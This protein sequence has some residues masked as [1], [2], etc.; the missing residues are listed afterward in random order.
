MTGKE[1]KRLLEEQKTAIAEETERMAE[2]IEREHMTISLCRD[3]SE[4]TDK[5]LKILSSGKTILHRFYIE[6]SQL[7]G[8]PLN[9]VKNLRTINRFY[10]NA[11]NGLDKQ[12]IEYVLGKNSISIT[13]KIAGVLERCTNEEKTGLLCGKIMPTALIETVRS[14]SAPSCKTFEELQQEIR[15]PDAAGNLKL[16]DTAKLFDYAVEQIEKTV[17]RLITGEYAETFREKDAVSRKIIRER[18]ADL[19]YVVKVVLSLTDN[20]QNS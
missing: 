4:L 18:C 14:R 12:C 11:D 8:L 3:I 6:T 9:G 10:E 16:S 13:A 20:T 15:D 5:R 7:L 2:R 17:E 19:E 1:Q